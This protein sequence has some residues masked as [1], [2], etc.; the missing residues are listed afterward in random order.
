M[1]RAAVVERETMSDA[2]ACPMRRAGH[3]I[4]DK[5]GVISCVLCH[6][7]WERAEPP[8]ATWDFYGWAA[9]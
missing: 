5:D 1:S 4:A 6:R 7:T 2:E 9:R 3:R 8:I